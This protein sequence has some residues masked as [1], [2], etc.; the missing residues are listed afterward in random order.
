[1]GKDVMS[2]GNNNMVIEINILD[3]LLDYNTLPD[4]KVFTKL[5]LCSNLIINGS[6]DS[7]QIMIVGNTHH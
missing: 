1:M 6:F 4:E 2:C 5:T 7:C 3:Y